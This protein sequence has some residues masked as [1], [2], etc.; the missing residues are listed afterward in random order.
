MVVTNAERVALFLNGKPAGEKPVDRYQMVT[1]DVP[2]EPGR[3][4]ARASN[5]GSEVA[6]FAVETTGAPAA[7]RLIPDRES[8]AGDGND[9]EPVSVEIVDAQGRVVPTADLPVSFSV[10]GPATIIGLNNGDP[11]NHEPEKGSQHSTYRGLAQVIVQSKPGGSGTFT[12]HAASP[13]LTA[14]DA[15]VNVIAVLEPPAVAEVHP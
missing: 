13:G 11:N 1:F 9:A 12:L 2:Y 3:L 6:R 8:M 14:G 7:I 10:S 15:S 5:G 4:E